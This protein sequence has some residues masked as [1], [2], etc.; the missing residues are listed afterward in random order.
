MDHTAV[1]GR[2]NLFFELLQVALGT[3]DRLSRVPSSHEWE[4]MY[5]ESERQ[6]VAS[7]LFSGIERLPAEQSPPID[8]K[9]QLIGAVQ[10]DEAT[11]KMHC[12]R[13]AGL[14][15]RCRAVGFRSCVLKGVGIAQYYPIPARRISGDIDLW[16]SG[17]RKDV[18]AW[19]RTKYEIIEVRWHHADAQIFGDV[20]TEIHFHATWLFNPIHNWRL[21]RYFESEKLAQMIEREEG[22]GYPSAEF[23]AVY[24]LVHSFHH[25]LECGIGFRH[26]V[27]YYYIVLHLSEA[28]RESV[29]GVV[30]S[31]G[32]YGFLRAMMYVLKEA[33]GMASEKLLCQPDDEEG[34]FL[35]HEIMAGGN[36]GYSRTDGKD[37]NTFS[38]WS[39]MVKHYPG[40][41]LW[42]VP[43]K[44]WH[45]SWRM[46]H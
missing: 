5:K 40:E 13:A 23:N 30:K 26:I 17:R 1:I 22:F 8:V 3:R 36:F 14:T 32:L 11:Y 10:M 4:E 15:R 34:E 19:L 37:V 41:V 35:L 20:Q 28:D 42:M 12:K 33:C 18:M 45:W 9:I 2:M 46:T 29:V 44:V 39:M 16:V 6:A 24:S 7:F 25:L 27:D 21:Q 31:T 38:R 43:W